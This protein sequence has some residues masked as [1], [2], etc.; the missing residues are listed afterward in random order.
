MR[1]PSFKTI[2]LAVGFAI[3]SSAIGAVPALAGQASSAN[4][5]GGYPITAKRV[6]ALRECNARAA[7]YYDYNWGVRQSSIYRACMAEHG[8]IE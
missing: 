6:E 1:Y 3:A 7:P 8:E 4:N 2:A 5:G